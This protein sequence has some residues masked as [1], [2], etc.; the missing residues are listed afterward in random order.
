MNDTTGPKKV[1]ILGGGVA[2]LVTAFEIT[3]QP[4]W[5]ERFD[6][7][8]HQ[9]GWRLGGKCASSRGANGRI[10]EHGIH[11]FLGSYYNALPLMAQVYAELGRQPGEPLATFDEAFLPENFVL[12]WE[13]RNRALQRWPQTLPTNNLG[14]TDGTA[15]LA[16]ERQLAAVCEF[17]DD[18]IQGHQPVDAAEGA[19]V[20][21]AKGPGLLPPC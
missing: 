14:P 17:L 15:F 13:F 11:G 19:L 16:I 12:M 18:L 3:S 5:Q 1:A 8:V 20:A 6:I 2:G 4:G 21:Q 7:T 10:E 9:L